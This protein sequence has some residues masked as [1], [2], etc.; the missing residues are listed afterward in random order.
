MSDTPCPHE[1]LIID[2][3]VTLY[4]DKPRSDGY[5]MLRAD[6]LCDASAE[7]A[8]CQ[9][10]DTTFVISDDP[11]VDG[12]LQDFYDLRPCPEPYWY[13]DG[14]ATNATPQT[15]DSRARLIDPA[16][17]IN[18]RSLECGELSGCHVFGTHTHRFLE[19]IYPNDL[20]RDP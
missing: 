14:I 7:M 19:L 1:N 2:A 3:C 15:G 8:T 9:E 18:D 12:F 6:G 20:Q 17:I 10:C 16:L 5:Y 11:P 13:E 4:A